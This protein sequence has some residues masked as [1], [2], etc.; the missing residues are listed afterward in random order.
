VGAGVVVGRDGKR[1]PSALELRMAEK[2][3]TGFYNSVA[4]VQFD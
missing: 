4:K 3:G 1:A 2:Q